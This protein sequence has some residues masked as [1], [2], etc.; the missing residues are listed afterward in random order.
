[1]SQDEIT[2][3]VRNENRVLLVLLFA[4]VLATVLKPWLLVWD[5]GAPLSFLAAWG[6]MKLLVWLRSFGLTTESAK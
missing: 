2:R 5:L 6:A 4:L 3:A 1:M